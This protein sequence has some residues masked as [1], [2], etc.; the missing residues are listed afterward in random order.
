MS[1]SIS[2][3]YNNIIIKIEKISSYYKKLQDLEK[4]IEKKAILDSYLQQHAWN[5][6]LFELKQIK[7]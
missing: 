7:R 4:K 2:I 1:I 5:L 6:K 3:N